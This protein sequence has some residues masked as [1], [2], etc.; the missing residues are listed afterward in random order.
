MS[1]PRLQSVL[2]VDDDPD[3]CAVVQTTLCLIAGLNVRTA[4]CGEE[5]IEQA[6]SSRPDLILMDVMMPG[7]DGPS[8]LKRMRGIARIADVPVIF[9]TA[10][11]LPIEVDQYLKLGAIGVIGKPF[12]PVKLC[13]D[14][15][16]L[17]NKPD[18]A[19]ATASVQGDPSLVRDE[20]HSLTQSFL[21]RARDDVECLRKILERT[22]ALD[23]SMLEEMRRAAHS[24][25]GAA[26]IFGFADLSLAGEAIEHLVEVALTRL[27]A[28]SSP[29]ELTVLRQQL[30]DHTDRLAREVA[31][32]GQTK[33][34]SRGCFR[35]EAEVLRTKT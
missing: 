8:T 34:S 27:A 33:S 30:L 25:H 10:K 2:Y 19:G 5:A 20:V 26:A 1:S 35:T 18:A 9:L 11:V 14:L 16:A 21:Q 12:D 13:D 15:L 31:A 4:A 32:A 7:L 28:V 22:R 29:G 17:R 3:I 24:I 23:R 6:C